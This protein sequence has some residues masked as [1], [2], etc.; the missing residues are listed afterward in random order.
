MKILKMTAILCLMAALCA[1]PALAG[2]MTAY[3]D[4]S[5]IVVT[6]QIGGKGELTVSQAGWPICVRQ[7]S[8]G[9]GNARIRVDDPNGSYDLRLNVSGNSY[10]FRIE[11]T[12]PEPTPVVTPKPTEVPTPKPSP[13]PQYIDDL[14]DEAVRLINEERAS[15]G[16][17][18]LKNSGTLHKAAKI[19]AQEIAQSFSHT[20]PDGSAWSTVSGSA[21]AE[22][23][24]QG[25]RSA[26]RVVASWMTSARS[27]IAS[28][29][30]LPI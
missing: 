28:L 4:G 6:W 17:D 30:P 10:T 18:P 27:D 29:S 16:L 22:N 9:S 15:R 21:Y 3:M 20:R 8:G 5:D 13:A 11:G 23:I 14:A 26:E 19:R 12:S 2:G 7:I 25:Q 24:A 1:I